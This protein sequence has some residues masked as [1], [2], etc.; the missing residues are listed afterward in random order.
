MRWFELTVH[1]DDRK[2]H[3]LWGYAILS[4]TIDK[5]YF[6][7]TWPGIENWVSSLKDWRPALNDQ[8]AFDYSQMIEPSGYI[9]IQK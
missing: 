2:P 6:L 3:F 4:T 5:H 9:G 8:A 1:F 7:K